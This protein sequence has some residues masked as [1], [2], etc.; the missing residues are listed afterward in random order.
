MEIELGPLTG[1][2]AGLALLACAT[3][4][5]TG[6]MSS[7]ILARA[8]SAT[9]SPR[10]LWALAGAA[11]AASGLWSNYCLSALALRADLAAAPGA[12]D[13]ALTL[14]C[15]HLICTLAFFMIIFHGTRVSTL[16][17]AAA[18]GAIVLLIQ[19]FSLRSSGLDPRLLIDL[20]AIGPKAAILAIIFVASVL[21]FRPELSPLRR[22]TGVLAAGVSVTLLNLLSLAQIPASVGAPS[23]TVEY[24][25]LGWITI[26]AISV[27]VVGIAAVY[28]LDKMLA[29]RGRQSRA[30]EEAAVRLQNSNRAAKAAEAA[31]SE[32]VADISHE[33]RTPLTAVLGMLDLLDAQSLTLDQRRHVVIAKT[34][35]E[36]LATLADD[37]ADMAKLDAGKFEPIIGPC[38]LACVA[39]SVVELMRSALHGRPVEMLLTIS[40]GFP[41]AVLTDSG[42]VRQILFNLIGNAVKFTNRG[43]ITIALDARPAGGGAYDVVIAVE[44][45]GASPSLVSAPP[46]TRFSGAELGVAISAKLAATLGGALTTASVLGAGSRF[47]FR[48]YAADAEATA[49]METRGADAASESAPFLEERSLC[50]IADQIGVTEAQAG[51]RAMMSDIDHLLADVR[52]ALAT[53]DL[54]EAEAG[55]HAV[56]D[57]AASWGA[58]RLRNA[59]LQFERAPNNAAAA[60]A[61]LDSMVKSWC[62][63]RAIFA[64]QL[65][66]RSTAQADAA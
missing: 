55:A 37:L 65:A 23:A 50:E 63:A 56:K 20:V 66:G 49:E 9:G 33:I 1:S 8:A 21:A 13:I 29:D 46:Q 3:S 47:V 42:R 40:E 41:S 38:D 52:M 25:S 12:S 24:E 35:A 31:R 18:V 62:G 45:T 39:Q 57:L 28:A 17:G 4:V 2:N 64:A 61:A 30:L 58:L 60:D 10:A 51:M 44:V 11:V 15:V 5:L 7:A 48:F 43:A 6:A 32:L 16:V 27:I 14:F 54:A 36:G 53:G 59:A 19:Y 34:A 22:F 26:L